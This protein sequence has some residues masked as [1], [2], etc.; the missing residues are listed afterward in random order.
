MKKLFTVTCLLTG[1][2]SFG[3]PPVKMHSTSVNPLSNTL[4]VLND[5]LATPMDD[6]AYIINGEEVLGFPFLYYS[7][8]NGLVTTAD[9]RTFSNYRLK[10][11]IFNQTIFFSNGKDSL[12]ASDPI[13]EFYLLIPEDKTQRKYTFIHSD[14][15]KKEKNPFYYEVM[16]DSANWE[17]LKVNRKAVVVTHNALPVYQGKKVFQLEAT[18]F[19][20]N[21][22]AKKIIPVKNDWSLV[23]AS[24]KLTKEDEARLNME[25]FDFSKE[26]DIVSFFELFTRVKAF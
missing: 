18:Y 24:L 3:Q 13:K 5:R 23:S 8:N 25:T 26:P 17:L 10:Y 19:F 1:F 16:A 9:G 22:Q 4:N 7:W 14:Q 6:D 21:K 11:N 20:Y 2:L 15:F 12:E